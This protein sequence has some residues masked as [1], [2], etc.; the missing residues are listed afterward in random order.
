MLVPMEAIRQI[1]GTLLASLPPQLR[2]DAPVLAWPVVAGGLM[3][4]RVHAC[5]CRQGVLQLETSDPAW[6]K[7]VARAAPL[8]LREFERLLGPGQVR[9]L[10]CRLISA[11]AAPGVES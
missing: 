1:L 4:R 9:E 5:A 2:D 6:G 3:G 10:N 11:D 7:E 8:I